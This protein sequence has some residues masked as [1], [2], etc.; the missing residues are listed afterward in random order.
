MIAR[1]S[2]RSNRVRPRQR[3]HLISRAAQAASIAL[4]AAILFA[5][6]PHASAGVVIAGTRVVY[7]AAKREVTI[8]VHNPSDTPSLVQAW[9]DA[10]DP[11]S[12]PGEANVP[13]VMTPPLFRLD[14]TKSQSLRLVYTHDPLPQDRESLFW[15]NVLDIPP[16]G[17]TNPDLPN[18]LE[19]AFK[20]RMKVFFRPT[21]LYGSAAAAPAQLK[22]KVEYKDGK[23]VGIQ[24]SN[25]TAYHVSLTQIS[26]TVSG[27][28]PIIA[29]ADMV[30]PFG[31]RSF[32]LPNPVAAPSGAIAVEYWFVNDY[33]GTVNG[34]ASASAAP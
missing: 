34:T 15:L 28:Q 12:K 4:V 16:R 21:G 22:W 18:Q 31:S 20:H 17:K 29:K 27:Q 1:E 24:A 33:G 32:D 5:A 11:H 8:D 23:L 9:L 2:F 3:L 25:P 13:F 14:P 30:D 6:A 19:L 10:G 7:L 26:A